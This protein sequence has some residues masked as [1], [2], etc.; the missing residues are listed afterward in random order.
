VNN[1]KKRFVYVKKKSDGDLSKMQLRAQCMSTQAPAYPND[2]L[3][4]VALCVVLSAAYLVFLCCCMACMIKTR[5]QLGVCIARLD[6]EAV[7]AYVLVTVLGC[8]CGTVASQTAQGLVDQQ[9]ADVAV[10]VQ[11]YNYTDVSETT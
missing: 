4:S 6:P 3:A 10:I 11:V 2:P 1:K 5:R 8:V 7:R 9:R